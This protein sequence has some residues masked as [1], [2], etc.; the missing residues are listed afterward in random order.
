MLF[1]NNPPDLSA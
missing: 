1:Y